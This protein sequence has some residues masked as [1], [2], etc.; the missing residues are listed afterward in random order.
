ERVLRAKIDMTSANMNLRD[1]VIYR[2]INASQAPGARATNDVTRRPAPT[3]H[4]GILWKNERGFNCRRRTTLP[5][6]SNTVDLKNGLRGQDV[7]GSHA[8][9]GV[10][11][12][13]ATGPYASH[14]RE[15]DSYGRSRPETMSCFGHV[16]HWFKCPVNGLSEA[17]RFS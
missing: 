10:G 7:H 8:I 15:I 16:S 9:P 4:L 13:L 12:A 6:A 14:H 1:P 17:L 2:I 3:R 11:P 5:P